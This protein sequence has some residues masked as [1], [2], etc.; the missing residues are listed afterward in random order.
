V[1]VRQGA[2]G[3]AVACPVQG[4]IRE[5]VAELAAQPAGVGEQACEA[6]A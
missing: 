3:R 2:A 4:M 1:S 5:P 6:V